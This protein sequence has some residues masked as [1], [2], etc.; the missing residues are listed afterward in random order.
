MELSLV[1]YEEIVGLAQA[2]LSFIKPK[3][4]RLKPS[5]KEEHE[6]ISEII[7]NL[8]ALINDIMGSDAAFDD[9]IFKVR[10]KK[11]QP[12]QPILK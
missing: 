6:M 1:N 5:S 7:V 4:L 12:P 10:N 3:F 2:N 11:V 8:L 9:L